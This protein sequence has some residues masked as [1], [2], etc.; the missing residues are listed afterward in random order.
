MKIQILKNPDGTLWVE[1][2]DPSPQPSATLAEEAKANLAEETTALIAEKDSEIVRLKESFDAMVAESVP[3]G[4]IDELIK[5][6]WDEADDA[7]KAKLA[8]QWGIKLAS[9]PEADKSEAKEKV[10]PPPK[11]RPAIRFVLKG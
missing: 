9:P 7:K 10:M 1:L 11:P 2:P 4:K 5:Q 3:L 6:A 8:E